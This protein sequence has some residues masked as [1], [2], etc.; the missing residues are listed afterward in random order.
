MVL[1]VKIGDFSLYEIVKPVCISL[2]KNEKCSIV[3]IKTTVTDL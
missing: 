2:Y 3:R 1:A